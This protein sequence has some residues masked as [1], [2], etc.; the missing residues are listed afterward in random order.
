MDASFLPVYRVLVDPRQSSPRKVS[1]QEFHLF[2]FSILF[3]HYSQDDLWHLSQNMK[4]NI[5]NDYEQGAIEMMVVLGISCL[6]I[7]AAF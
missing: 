4:F 6:V 1:T 5:K 3:T 2:I 7:D